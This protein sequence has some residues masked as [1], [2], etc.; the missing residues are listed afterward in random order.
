MVENGEWITRETEDCTTEDKNLQNL[1][2]KR[3][4]VKARL[5]ELEESVTR[6]ELRQKEREEEEQ[7]M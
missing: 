1:Q 7:R 4:K 2:D 5:N 6:E 3:T